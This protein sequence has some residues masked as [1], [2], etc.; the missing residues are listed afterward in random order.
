VSV[1]LRGLSWGHRRANGPLGPLTERFRQAHPDIAI[2][3]SVRPLSDF[4]HQG[5]A[6]VAEAFD[7]VIFDHPFSGDVVAAGAFVALDEAIAELE[8][9]NETRFAGPSLGSYRY[10]GHVWGAPIDA[11]T[12]H[13]LVRPDLMGG[14]PLPASW[15][16]MLALG[17]RLGRRGLHLG[18]AGITPHAGLT[19]AA[20]MC[21]AGKAWST[22]PQAPFAIDPDGLALA[23]DQ[24][25]A[26]AAFAPPEALGWNSIELHDAMV[27]RDDIAFAPC[28]YGYATYGEA[29]L[30]RRLA[31]GPFPGPDGTPAGTVLGGTALGL[32]R[33]CP[34]RNE[35]L[36]FL[37]FCLT[38]EAQRSIIP[39]HHG[40]PALA[41]AWADA[42][43]DRRFNGFFSATHSTI[44][45]AW[46][47]P[48]LPG[49]LPFQHAAGEAVR[50]ML[51]GELTARAAVER[52]LALAERVGR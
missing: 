41:S 30:R 36:L 16:G 39:H 29:D 13:A 40:Q 18:F 34:H 45:S 46:V 19:V 20:L 12:Q 5:I 32:S 43:I 27:A 52:I 11:A 24:H 1:R 31:F 25:R 50:Q 10:G 2:E 3:W 9:G 38:E 47:R 6:G 51:A 21:N 4:E 8:T 14:E 48:R 17:E 7:L 28:V 23:L 26:L 35:A 15:D 37:R 42:E 22:D 49:Y 33:R 44:D